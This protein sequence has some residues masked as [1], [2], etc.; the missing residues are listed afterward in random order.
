MSY[1]VCL[2]EDDGW[3]HFN[4][5]TFNRPVFDLL[6][7]MQ[8]LVDGAKAVLGQRQ[9]TLVCRD[10]LAESVKRKYPNSPVNKLNVS[11]PCL[12]INASVAVTREFIDEINLSLEKNVLFIQDSDIVAMHLSG[13]VLTQ[14]APEI[15]RVPNQE[16]LMALL[17]E[18]AVVKALST[19]F[20]HRRI[21]DFFASHHDVLRTQFSA[22]GRQGIIKGEQSPYALIKQ[23]NNVFVAEQSKIEDFVVLDASKGPIYVGKDVR[24]KA[25]SYIEGPTYIGDGSEIHHAVLRGSSIGPH[26]KVGGEVSHSIIQGFTNKAHYGYLGHSFLGEWV[27]LG[28]GT[29][30]S[31]L[32]NNYG[33]VRLEDATGHQVETG[34]MFFGV[35]MGDHV[36]AG[37]G[38]RFNAG[39]LVGYGSSL[40]GA[41]AHEKW[42]SPFTWGESRQYQ[43][44]DLEKFL[45]TAEAMMARRHQTLYE[46]DKALMTHLHA[47]LSTRKQ[48]VKVS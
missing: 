21:W 41:R 14:I 29:T 33:S 31:N 19:S 7:G 25:H 48:T 28:A 46:R 38:S 39:T 44:H 40:F 30:N 42:I 35:A 12:F 34:Q 47:N 45:K 1:T 3:H 43:V 4:P 36:K 37:I 27:N 32:K 13:D 20:F 9:M 10:Y 8:T 11:R 16:K 22:L 15:E 26:C 5:L 2:Y 18:K 6:V 23:E 24:I 17:R